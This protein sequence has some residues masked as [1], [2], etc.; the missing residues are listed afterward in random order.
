MIQARLQISGE[1]NGREG[2]TGGINGGIKGIE[3]KDATI[4]ERDVR[5]GEKAYAR[6]KEVIGT[7]DESD[8]FIFSAEK[9]EY[10]VGGIVGPVG[11]VEFKE[12]DLIMLKNS[13]VIMN[14]PQEL[15]SQ[16]INLKSENIIAGEEI[17]DVKGSATADATATTNSLMEGQTAYV[18]GKKITGIIKE[19][20][21]SYSGSGTIV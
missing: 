9:I 10:M 19:Y 1:I 2:L 6:G 14:F 20:D 15:L 11:I 17:L 21:G 3:T 7:L 5:I 18:N 13:Q 12:E 4:T 16:A 8:N